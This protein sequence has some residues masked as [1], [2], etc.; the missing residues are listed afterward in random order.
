[1]GIATLSWS[2]SYINLSKRERDRDRDEEECH[3]YIFEMYN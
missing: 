3:E 2:S 1:M